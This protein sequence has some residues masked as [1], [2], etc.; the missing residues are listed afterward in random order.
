MF[1]RGRIVC[2]KIN[3]RAMPMGTIVNTIDEIL[4]HLSVAKKVMAGS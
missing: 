3:G 4:E 1:S 2:I